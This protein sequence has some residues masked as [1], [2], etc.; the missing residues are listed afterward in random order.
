M[1]PYVLDAN[2]VYRFLRNAPGSEIVDKVFKDARRADS[3]VLMSVVN[4]G[5]VYYNLTKRVGRSVAETAL[6]QLGNLPLSIVPAH[7]EHAR[8]AAELKGTFGL[9]YADCFA[10]SLA[11]KEGVVVTADVKDFRRIPWLQLLELPVYKRT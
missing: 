2:A 4:W 7:I 3:M 6:T 5:E 9:P 10:A 1:K 8:A 11:G